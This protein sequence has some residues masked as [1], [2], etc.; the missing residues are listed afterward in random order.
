MLIGLTSFNFPCPL[1]YSPSLT[2]H[3]FRLQEKYQQTVQL[4]QKGESKKTLKCT[5]L[6]YLGLSCSQSPFHLRQPVGLAIRSWGN[7]IFLQTR[8]VT[9]SENLPTLLRSWALGSEVHLAHWHA[10]PEKWNLPALLKL[11]SLRISYILRI[12]SDILFQYL[13]PIGHIKHNRML[14]SWVFIATSCV[15]SL[16]HLSE[17]TNVQVKLS[18]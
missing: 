16:E 8:L 11:W 6:H 12:E 15:F 10:G 4:L 7:K 9:G 18:E 14:L 1:C 3:Q 2:H 17:T 5:M 13:L